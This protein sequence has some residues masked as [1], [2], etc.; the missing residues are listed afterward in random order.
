[1]I[2]AAA[3]HAGSV[4]ADEIRQ[5][6]AT[7]TYD[8]AMGAVSFDDHNQAVLPMALLEIVDGEPVI[9]EMITTRVDYSLAATGQ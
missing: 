2:A 3:R 6:M 7:F 8:G 4:N 1:L 9:K 5:A